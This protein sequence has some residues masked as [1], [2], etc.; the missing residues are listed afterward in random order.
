MSSQGF[1]SHRS[2]SD[3]GRRLPSS[4]SDGSTSEISSEILRFSSARNEINDS[5]DTTSTRSTCF[6]SLRWSS[7]TNESVVGYVSSHSLNGDSHRSSHLP[8][9][10]RQQ[11]FIPPCDNPYLQNYAVP[12]NSSLSECKSTCSSINTLCSRGML[13]SEEAGESRFTPEILSFH[14]AKDL[15]LSSDETNSGSSSDSTFGSNLRSSCSTC[16]SNGSGPS[17]FVSSPLTSSTSASVC[18]NCCNVSSA[19]A[20]HQHYQAP[21]AVLACEYLKVRFT[22]SRPLFVCPNYR[23]QQHIALVLSLFHC[24]YF[25]LLRQETGV[26]DGRKSQRQSPCRQP[27][28]SNTGEFY[29]VPKNLKAGSLGSIT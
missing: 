28:M 13:Q 9:C 16:S 18:C 25:L 8:S 29:D 21:R 11:P 1:C 7:S 19:S 15:D 3:S 5:E 20:F 23:Q 6:T 26:A 27:I 12:R 14:M 4:G 17:V 24:K 22:L 10:L 2:G